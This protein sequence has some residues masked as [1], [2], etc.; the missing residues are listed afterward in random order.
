MLVVSVLCAGVSFA[1][2]FDAPYYDLEKRNRA[3][4]AKE[5]KAV[6]AKLAKLERKYG[7]NFGPKFM[8]YYRHRAGERPGAAGS[9]AFRALR[10]LQE[11][12][13]DL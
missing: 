3:T 7:M 10:F 8:P 4:W 12:R 6:Q 2:Q 11:V 1:Q 13:H 5:D 9:C